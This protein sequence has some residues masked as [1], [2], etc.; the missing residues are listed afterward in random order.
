MNGTVPVPRFIAK[1]SA[2]PRGRIAE[3]DRPRIDFDSLP[4][5]STLDSVDR[6]RGPAKLAIGDFHPKIVSYVR[7]ALGLPPRRGLPI[8]MP[9]QARALEIGR[10]MRS[11]GKVHVPELTV[12]TTVDQVDGEY[13]T[14]VVANVRVSKDTVPVN[15]PAPDVEYQNGRATVAPPG[16]AAPVLA[17]VPATEPTPHQAEFSAARGT[18]RGKVSTK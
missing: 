1:G 2:M 4:D 5:A 10:Q 3:A 7:T 17:T 11:Y 13:R 14:I 6:T 18:A 12:T 15:A 8:P 9:D 16:E